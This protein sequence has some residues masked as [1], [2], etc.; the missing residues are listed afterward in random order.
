MC[1]VV[2]TSSAIHIL[3]LSMN[4]TGHCDCLFCFF[5]FLLFVHLFNKV[6]STVNQAEA[7]TAAHF[8]FTSH[9]FH[10]ESMRKKSFI[11]I[12]KHYNWEGVQ[13]FHSLIV[14]SGAFFYSFITFT[15]I[16]LS[17]PLPFGAL[18]SIRCIHPVNV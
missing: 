4:E 7:P 10:K 5:L 17:L 11:R 16:F 12:L 3:R 14:N 15:F 2:W 6:R 8:S 9:I 13:N 18:W 1:V